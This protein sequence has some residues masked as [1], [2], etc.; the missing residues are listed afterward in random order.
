MEENL[1]LFHSLRPSWFCSSFFLFSLVCSLSMTCHLLDLFIELI[2][3]EFTSFSFLCFVVWRESTDN[4]KDR[5]IM[6]IRSLNAIILSNVYF[7]SL[8]T[9]IIQVVSDC[10]FIFVI[11]CAEF[12]YQ[13]RVHF[14]DRH[15]LIVIIHREQKTFNVVVM[16]F[17]N[18]SSYVQR[19]IDRVLRSY[20][21]YFRAYID[22]IV[23]FFKTRQKY[24]THLRKIF[25]VL[26]Q[27]NIVVNSLKTFIEF[28]SVTLLDQRITS[29]ELS[30]EVEKMKVIFD[31]SFSQTLN[32]LNIY[33]E[34]TDWFR[35]YVFNYAAKSE[36]L[37][38]CK[39][40]M[41]KFV[42]KVENTK[43]SYIFKTKLQ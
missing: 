39:T 11:D 8:Q 5:M 17:R 16:R 34:F 37:Q 18:S 15:K 33:L 38:K 7:I 9:D 29:L 35:Q 41:L 32:E 28:S 26:I 4:R 42:S 43:K 23:I 27:N 10:N 14:E 24:M 40:T 20:R 13:W 1:F 3:T 12:F 6:N 36:S 2:V 25:I 31:L 19:Q 30:I 22:D 21:D